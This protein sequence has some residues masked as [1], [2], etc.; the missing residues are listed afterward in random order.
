[1]GFNGLSS[2]C[3][4]PG[5]QQGRRLPSFNSHTALSTCSFLVFSCLT[6]IVQQIHSLRASGVR[7]SHFS[8]ATLLPVRAFSK[9]SGI[10]CA[11]PP[12]IACLF[13][14]FITATISLSRPSR[15]CATKVFSI[16]GEGE[17]RTRGTLKRTTVFETA[18]LNRSDTSPGCL[19]FGLYHKAPTPY[20]IPIVP[21]PALI[22]Q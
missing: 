4:H 5:Q 21:Y 18:S 16:D 8:R 7:D 1:M 9:S 14:F 10:V 19:I 2:R 12:E 22:R 6:V 15:G 11:T 3:G 13:M 17:I 20:T